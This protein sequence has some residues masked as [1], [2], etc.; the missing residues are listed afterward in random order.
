MKAS[1]VVI[2]SLIIYIRYIYGFE[3]CNKVDK[4][5][6]CTTHESNKQYCQGTGR[7]QEYT[8]IRDKGDVEEKYTEWRDC[9]VST[10][11]QIGYV[12]LFQLAMMCIGSFTYVQV[13][14]RKLNTMTRFDYRKVVTSTS[15]MQQ[16]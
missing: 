11:S 13:T 8:C 16:P 14:K 6:E 5:I 1:F 10:E 2:V 7:K 3:T 15:G 12:I 9:D 4:C